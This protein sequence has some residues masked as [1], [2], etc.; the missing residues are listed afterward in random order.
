MAELVI[1]HIVEVRQLRQ[2]GPLL[3]QVP[4]ARRPANRLQ[5]VLGG[6]GWEIHALGSGQRDGFTCPSHVLGPHSGHR[7]H[8]AFRIRRPALRSR[9]ADGFP[10]YG[11][12]IA[13][14]YMHSRIGNMFQPTRAKPRRA[15]W[16][17]DFAPC[18]AAQRR[19]HLRRTS[20]HRTRDRALR[21]EAS[22]ADNLLDLAVHVLK[23]FEK[24]L[25]VRHPS[26]SR[27]YTPLQ[28]AHGTGSE[29][30]GDGFKALSG[31]TL[32]QGGRRE[33]GRNG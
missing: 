29:M 23:K 13:L 1:V 20:M 30:V 21:R 28:M 17:L 16:H 26:N 24:S 19:H 12:T 2:R 7:L 18:N 10:I 25:I 15:P 32:R 5:D 33:G 6:E 14:I 11:K 4:T 8:P 27:G 3:H 22:R 31:P 9:P